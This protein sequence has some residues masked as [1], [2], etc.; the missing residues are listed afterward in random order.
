M[1]VD[2]SALAFAFLITAFAGLSTG[3]GSLIGLLAKTTKPRLLAFS[4]GLSAGVMVYISFVEMY[5]FA[6]EALKDEFGNKLGA[7]YALI[8]FFGG[9]ALT[10]VIDKL[11]P[12]FEN[13]HEVRKIE[14][15][16][17]KK[18]KKK[19]S[20]LMRVG[21]FSSI[22]IALHNFPEGIATFVSGLSSPSIGIAIALA[23]AI[24][25]IPEGI[26]V[27]VPIY[28]ATGSR[29][30]AFWYS[31]ATG[32]FEPLG[33]LF[34]WYVIFPLFPNMDAELFSGVTL[35]VV[36]GIMVYISFDEL[37]PSAEEYGEHHIAIYGL[38]SGM[39]IMAVSLLAFEF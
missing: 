9:I 17:D 20:S 28:Y 27:S 12:A 19:L 23:V 14:D 7:A 29:K 21:I 32:L 18:Q 13:P 4:L 5:P 33:A 25:N 10:A 35:G 6:L 16:H 31:F 38:I 1:I 26:A 30:K 15:L 11:I 24:H 3:I 34:A 39:A 2:N 22:V 36:A 37:L 8:A